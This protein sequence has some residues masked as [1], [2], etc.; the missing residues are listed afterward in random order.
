L[1]EIHNNV[2]LLPVFFISSLR[3]KLKKKLNFMWEIEKVSVKGAVSRSLKA[4]P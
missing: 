2:I 4:V 1:V 3:L